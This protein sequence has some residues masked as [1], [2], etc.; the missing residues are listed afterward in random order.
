M[1]Q[2]PSF[3]LIFLHSEFGLDETAEAVGW[4][5]TMLAWFLHLVIICS[6]PCWDLA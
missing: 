5:Y 4:I 6:Y 1:V 2:D 3:P